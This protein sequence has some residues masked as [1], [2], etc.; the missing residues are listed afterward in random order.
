M[1]NN[2]DAEDYVSDDEDNVGEEELDDTK[3]NL[4]SQVDSD[5]NPRERINAFPILS[6]YNQASI[7]G[8]R[9]EQL[10]RGSRTVLSKESEEEVVKKTIDGKMVNFEI[11][12]EELRQKIIP[13]KVAMQVPDKDQLVEFGIDEFLIP[14]S[15][16]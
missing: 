3:N 12:K 14:N 9:V 15:I 16:E 4:L 13:I 10:S 1:D 6:V 5:T 2:S 11:A 7:L 8:A